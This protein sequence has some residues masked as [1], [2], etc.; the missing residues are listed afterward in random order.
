MLATHESPCFLD[1]GVLSLLGTLEA[2][3]VSD[4][5]L[6]KLYRPNSLL[7]FWVV[8]LLENTPLRLNRKGLGLL[9]IRGTSG[10]FRVS[11]E[12]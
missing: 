3:H 8:V 7:V 1:T 12:D 5:D 10:F 6:V 4:D 11:T 9:F 2:P